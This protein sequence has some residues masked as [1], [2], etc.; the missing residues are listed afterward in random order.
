[1]QCP[2]P[3]HNWDRARYS[4][5]SPITN[6]MIAADKSEGLLLEIQVELESPEDKFDPFILG[7]RHDVRTIKKECVLHCRHD[8]K[9]ENKA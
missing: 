1:M 8:C 5:A 7:I 6:L 3:L 4:H 9:K 2:M